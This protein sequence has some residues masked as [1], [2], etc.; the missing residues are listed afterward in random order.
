MVTTKWEL[1]S[2][3]LGPYQD[4]VEQALR[5]MERQDIIARIW[6]HD[7]TVW[8]PD[9]PGMARYCGKDGREYRLPGGIGWGRAC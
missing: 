4:D 8:K 9:P 2:A 6:A 1:L 7:Y 5:E 3:H